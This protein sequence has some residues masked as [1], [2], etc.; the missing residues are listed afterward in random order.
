MIK[1][2]S[3]ITELTKRQKELKKDYLFRQTKL[4]SPNTPP[5]WDSMWVAIQNSDGLKNELEYFKDDVERR[6]KEF[7]EEAAL[8]VIE[9]D[10]KNRYFDIIDDYKYLD[11]KHC[12]R[13]MTIPIGVDPLSISQLGIY[14]ATEERAAEAHWGHRAK[15]KTFTVIYRGVIDLNNVDW[16]GTMYA[17]MD[18]SLGEEEK[19]IRFIKNSKIFVESMYSDPNDKWIP[20]NDYRRT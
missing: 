16:A 15:G 18:M 6:G 10:Q 14:W 7:N 12:W 9:A 2:Q 8:Q 4:H 3:L 5:P 11:G 19:E 17:R 1:L 20:I 13:E